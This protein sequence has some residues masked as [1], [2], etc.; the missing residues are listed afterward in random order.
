MG[1]YMKG[2]QAICYHFM[3]CLTKFFFDDFG[4]DQRS[5]HDFQRFIYDIIDV[6]FA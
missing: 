5:D 6:S 4:S 3:D 2:M 1:K